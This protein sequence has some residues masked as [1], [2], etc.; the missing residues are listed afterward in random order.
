MDVLTQLIWK[1]TLV[2]TYTHTQVYICST[3]YEMRSVGEWHVLVTASS[4]YKLRVE[5]A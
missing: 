2:Y 4:L 1:Y 5:K 3:D